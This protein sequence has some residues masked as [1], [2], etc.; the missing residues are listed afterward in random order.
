MSAERQPLDVVIVYAFDSSKN[1]T[2]WFTVDD[3]VFWMVHEKLTQF[4]N[5][6]IGFIYFYSSGNTYTRDMKLVNSEEK[7]ADGYKRF[8]WRRIACT[9]NMAS[10][11]AQAHK[12]ISNRDYHNGIILFFSD[13]RINKGDFFDG[14][15]NFIS[16]YPVHTFT[17][18]EDAYNQVVLFN[19]QIRVHSVKTTN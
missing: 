7:K 16:K 9:R 5:S 18:G 19:Y 15:E 2:A 1:D 14:T 8:A 12:L 11:L 17:L 10:G 13:G 4:P 6:C 3:Q